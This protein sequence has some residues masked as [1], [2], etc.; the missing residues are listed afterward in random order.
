MVARDPDVIERQVSPAVENASPF[1]RSG[2]GTAVVLSHAAGDDQVL[3]DDPAPRQ[4]L[5]HAVAER[6]CADVG[7]V[8]PAGTLALD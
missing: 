5:E 1:R 7:R 3:Q 8:G 2:T 6:R 4:H